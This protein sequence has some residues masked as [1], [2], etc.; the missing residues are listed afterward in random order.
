[1]KKLGQRGIAAVLIEG[2]SELSAAALQD[3][4][5]DKVFFFYAP[6]IIGGKKATPMVGGTGISKVSHAVKVRDLRYRKVG[7]DILVEGYISK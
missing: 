1:M 5:V 7:D 2:G 4:I 6:V 3:G